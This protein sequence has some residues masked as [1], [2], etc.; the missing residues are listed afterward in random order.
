MHHRKIEKIVSVID[1]IE[2]HLSEKLDLEIISGAMHYSKY[3]LHRMFTAA[4]G[5]TLHD[6]IQRRRLTEAAKLLVFSE[7]P[8]LDIALKSGYESQQAFS[9]IFTA[10]Y[11]TS[12]GKYRENEK[13]YP[14]QLKFDFLGNYPMLNSKE[15]SNWNVTFAAEDDIPCWMQLV[16]LVIDWFPHLH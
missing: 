14:L 10:M 5:L 9:N 13:F 16:R 12:P 4:V 11:K 6:Y 3:H 15:D 2:S 1:Y 8:I 7:Q